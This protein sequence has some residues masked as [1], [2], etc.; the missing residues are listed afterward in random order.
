MK[1]CLT[2]VE[3]SV[4]DYGPPDLDP[5]R[6]GEFSPD[7]RDLPADLENLE[8]MDDSEDIEVMSLHSQRLYTVS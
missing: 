5:D 8:K 4:G 3:K 7:V 6:Q 1:I 2:E